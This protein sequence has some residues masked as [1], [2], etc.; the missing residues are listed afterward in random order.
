M[1]RLRKGGGALA[2]ISLAL[3]CLPAIAPAAITP[4]AEYRFHDNFASSVPGAADLGPLGGSSFATENIAGCTTR[5]L[6]F[7]QGSGLQLPSSVLP[8]GTRTIVMDV[9]LS[10]IPQSGDQYRRLVGAAS[11]SD[12]SGLY[13]HDGMLDWYTQSGAI[14]TEGSTKTTAAQWVEVILFQGVAMANFDKRFY[15]NGVLENQRVDASQFGGRLFQDN[16]PLPNDES[17]EGAVSRI[18]IYDSQVFPNDVPGV[19]ASGPLG[20]PGSCP[21]AGASVAGKPKAKKG[22]KLVDTGIL[23]SCP[24]HGVVCDG[25]ASIVGS[26]P[27]KSKAQKLGSLSLSIPSGGSQ[28]VIVGLSKRGRKLLRKKGKLKA[29]ASVTITGPNGRPVTAQTRGKIKY[30]GKKRR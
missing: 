5:V 28:K 26:G 24:D 18:A 13:F 11:P 8:S 1:S 3:A 17:A 20:N 16:D 2:V 30:P 4:T 22:G 27:K 29:T 15:L 6:S 14:D 23:A 25:A 9:R 7:P 21:A 12:D 19:Y 10:D